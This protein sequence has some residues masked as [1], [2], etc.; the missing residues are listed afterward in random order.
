MSPP[1]ITSQNLEGNKNAHMVIIPII[2]KINPKSS[3]SPGL[4]QNFLLGLISYHLQYKRIN[5]AKIRLISMMYQPERGTVCMI[6]I[7]PVIAITIPSNFTLT[8]ATFLLNL[9]HHPLSLYEEG[10]L[11]VQK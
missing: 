6:R 3:I 9:I 1:I 10:M 11:L 2:S 4:Q 5:R 8:F 7:P